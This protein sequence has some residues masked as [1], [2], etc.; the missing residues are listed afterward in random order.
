MTQRT[1]TADWPCPIARAVDELGDGWTLL[2]VRDAS[3]GARRF[4]DFQRSLGIGRNILADRLSRLVDRGIF[5]KEPYS[6]RPPRYEYRLTEKGREIFPILVAMAAWSDRW[7]SDPAGR[8][9]L[10]RHTGCDHDMHA[11]IVCGECGEELEKQTIRLRANPDYAGA[12]PSPLVE[13]T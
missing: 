7:H 13:R 10:A 2:I 6:E 12:A 11:R 1:S 8:P 4:D 3:L 5:T 9:V